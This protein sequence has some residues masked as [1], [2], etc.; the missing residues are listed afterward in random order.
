MTEGEEEGNKEEGE[1]WQG[2]G[3]RDI[4]PEGTK[5]CLWIKKKQMWPIGKWQFI[6]KKKGNSHVRMRFFNLIMSIR[7]VKRGLL[8]TGL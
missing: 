5:D 4:Y 7:I 6:K 2:R 3:G 8:T 1:G